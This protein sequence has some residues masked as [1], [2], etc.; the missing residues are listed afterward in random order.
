MRKVILIV[1]ALLVVL[2]VAAGSF[3]TVDPTVFVYVTQFGKREAVYDGGDNESDTGLH[4]RL[5]APLQS[6]QRIDRRL[7][8][9]DLPGIEVLTIDPGKDTIDKTLTIDAYVCWRIPDKEAVDLFIRRL[10][11]VEQAQAVLGRSVSAQVAAVV[12]KMSMDDLV[13]VK[14]GTV[15]AKMDGLR[16][17]LLA[18]QRDKARTEYGIQIVDIRI[19]RFNYPAQV[20]EA[21]FDRIRNERKAKAAEYEREGMT[22]A[23]EIRSSAGKKQRIIIADAKARAEQ[24]RGQAVAEADRIRNAAHRQDRDFYKFLKKLEDYGRILGDSK[25]VLYLSTQRELFDVFFNSNGT[26]STARGNGNGSPNKADAD[27]HRTKKGGK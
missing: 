4:H 23:A 25:T 5:P 7:Q 10:G 18:G 26:S 12:G 9:F 19:R 2:Y 8:V 20:R 27:T 21:I 16:K 13:N 17:K 15:K 1:V 14:P 6:V 11:S 3:V 22:L 24:L